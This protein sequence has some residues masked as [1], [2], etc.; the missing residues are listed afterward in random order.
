MSRSLIRKTQLHPDVADLFGD[1][2]KKIDLF[3]ALDRQTVS[4]SQFSPSPASYRRNS[5]L[6]LAF[7]DSVTQTAIFA[8]F[9]QE[10]TTL[11]LGLRITLHWAATTATSGNV[12]WL[13]SFNTLTLVSPVSPGSLVVG[14]SVVIVA[15]T[16]STSGVLNK[17][18][19]IINNVNA[20]ALGNGY[21]L[22]ISRIGQNP[23]D[24][25]LGAAELVLARVESEV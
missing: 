2:S 19:L 24:T 8:S 21:R 11:T 1:S 16:N 4:S 12:V 9:L 6:V 23:L 20:T 15:S 7:S 3:T 5:I 17:T 22:E 25:M 18:E 13:A 10:T 14:P